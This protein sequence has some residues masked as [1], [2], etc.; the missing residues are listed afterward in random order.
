ME[1]IPLIATITL[2]PIPTLGTHPAIARFISNPPTS[3]LVIYPAILV[4]AVAIL[5][6]GLGLVQ[7]WLA[8]ALSGPLY[9]A[10]VVRILFRHFV[11]KYGREPV[12]AAFN[13][14]RGITAD[15]S[16]AAGN[17]LYGLFIP[18]AIFGWSIWGSGLH[19]N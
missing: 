15:R 5:L 7:P 1:F 19:T 11:S 6:W 10:T 14:D 17:I 2:V 4:A 9:Q 12:D 18:M 8:I 16:F 3:M 13:F